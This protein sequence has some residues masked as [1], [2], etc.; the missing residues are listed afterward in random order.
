MISVELA[1][2]IKSLWAEGKMTKK[3]IAKKCNVSRN[4]VYR[5]V[6]GAWRPHPQAAAILRDNSSPH[7]KHV[8]H[9]CPECGG[10]VKMPCR[11]CADRKAEED[12]RAVRENLEYFGRL[13]I[14][15]N[16]G[17]GRSA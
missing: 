5:V 15:Q 3:A 11:K 9:R 4:L 16:G 2:K 17:H 13:T 6:R 1:E 8:M 14:G 7:K 10:L 12:R